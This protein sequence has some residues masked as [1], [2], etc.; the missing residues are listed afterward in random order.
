[1][2]ARIY[3]LI[4]ARPD[5]PQI[6]KEEV[7]SLVKMVEVETLEGDSANATKLRRWLRSLSAMAPDIF[8]AITTS[9]ANS[10]QSEFRILQK[11]LPGD[12]T[13]DAPPPKK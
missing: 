7:K 4:E 9:I 2:F 5:D 12:S 3:H 10:S 8:D 11:S 13:T 6:D 1:M